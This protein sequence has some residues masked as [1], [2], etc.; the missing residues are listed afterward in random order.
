MEDFSALAH[1]LAAGVGDARGSLILSRDGLVLGAF[2]PEAEGA[3]KPAWLR[4]AALGEPERGFVGFGTEIWS[5]VRRGA[6]AAFVITGPG[7]R[8]GLVIDQIEQVLLTA[9]EARAR[10]EGMQ[11][12]A[13]PPPTAP[14]PLS[15]PR[16][17]LHPDGRPAD[18]PVV[19]HA[20][21]SRPELA[22]EGPATAVRPPTPDRE[23][24]VEGPV[25]APEP[26][27]EAPEHPAEPPQPASG[28]WATGPREDEEEVD[29]F[30]IAREFSQLLQD[31]PNAADG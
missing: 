16:T 2:P 3:V 9:E 13:M 25:G 22:P 17:T 12:P 18:Q 14:A 29:R 8:P 30:S 26:P 27:A 15:K 6:Y 1:T 24:P 5:Y 31:D 20:E 11:T 23:A 4:F 10:R 28:V 19:V 21:P 7:V